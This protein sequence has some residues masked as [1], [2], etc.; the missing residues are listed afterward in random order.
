M[1]LLCD[2][3]HRGGTWFVSGLIAVT[4]NAGLMLHARLPW[5]LIVP[6]LTIGGLS[7]GSWWAQ[8][9]ILVGSVQ[10]PGML[11]NSCMLGMSLAL[12][13]VACLVGLPCV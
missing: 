5:S 10:D 9:R 13:P 2:T 12:L 1:V 6:L 4:C 8:S 7:P 11:A 3:C